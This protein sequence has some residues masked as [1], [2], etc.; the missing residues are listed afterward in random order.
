[1]TEQ[2]PTELRDWLAPL[3]D[4]LIPAEDGMP[5]AGQLGAAD[6]QLD[7]VLDA[8]PD[9]LR[10]LTRAYAL[11]G[12]MSP[13][14]ALSTLPGL[15]PAAH[16]ALLEAVAGG[17]YA[18]P[19]VR[20]LIGYTGQQPVPVRVADFPEY[21]AEGLLERVLERGPVYRAVD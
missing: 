21:L 17:Y 7:L 4:A 5:A 13:A 10:H 15:D 2:P 6:A 1:M 14:E 19:E 20:E 11:T 3:A 16:A 18:H 8:R 12:G 9:L